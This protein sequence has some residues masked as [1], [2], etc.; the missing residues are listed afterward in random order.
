MTARNI[1][2]CI[3]FALTQDRIC[4][5]NEIILS[6]NNGDGAGN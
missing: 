5:I 3:Q 1:Y 6:N 2:D 4:S